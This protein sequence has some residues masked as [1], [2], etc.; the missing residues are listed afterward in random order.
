MLCHPCVSEVDHRKC[1]R[2]AADDVEL[3]K[4]S[5]HAILMDNLG[6]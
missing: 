6:M 3:R 1:I 2:E 4:G 5:V